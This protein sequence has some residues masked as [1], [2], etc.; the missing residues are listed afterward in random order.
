MIV[1]RCLIKQQTFITPEDH[2]QKQADTQTLWN[3]INQLKDSY[4]DVLILRDI[5]ELSYEEIAEIL[6]WTLSKVKTT[7]HRARLELKRMLH[8]EEF[9]K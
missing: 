2:I 9:N 1:Y 5:Q 4:R 7:L 3:H 8:C 6:N